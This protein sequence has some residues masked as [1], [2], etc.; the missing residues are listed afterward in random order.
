MMT[1]RKRQGLRTVM[2]YS[3]L[4]CA[5]VAAFVL[6]PALFAFASA[7]PHESAVESNDESGMG[8]LAGT[9]VGPNG[10][11]AVGSRVTLQDAGASHPDVTLTNAQGRFFFAELHHGYY[12]VRAY[13]NGAWSDWKHN[14]EVKTGKQTE[15]RLQVVAKPKKAA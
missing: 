10:K 13:S 4:L 7:A 2:K 12:D 8:T 5:F 6:L 1:V 9:V 14:I 15:V 11:P 3:V